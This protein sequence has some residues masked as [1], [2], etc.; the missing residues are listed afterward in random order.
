[1]RPYPKL[2]VI[3]AV[4]VIVLDHPTVVVPEHELVILTPAHYEFVHVA[5][6]DA[7]PIRWVVIE[8]PAVVTR[9]V[10]RAWVGSLEILASVTA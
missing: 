10:S 5:E 7:G 9:R 2:L 6:Q 4:L 8:R 1:M 3:T